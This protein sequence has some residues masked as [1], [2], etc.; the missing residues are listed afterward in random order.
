MK[1]KLRK[2]ILKSLLSA[3]GVLFLALEPKP[4]LGAERISFTL[5]LFGEFKISVADLEVFAKEG[6]ITSE[7][8]FYASRLDRETLIE[9]RQGLQTKFDVEPFTVYQFTT[10]PMGEQFLRGLGEVASTHSE[11]NG[12]YAIRSALILA[13]A[14]SEGL[15]PLNFLRHFPTDEIHLNTQLIFSLVKEINSFF[16]YKD[17]TVRAIAAQAKSELAAQ[18]EPDFEH[19]PDLRQPGE[20]LVAKQTKT[21][22]INAV[23]Q[24]DIGFTESY[25]LEA[26]IYLPEGI[27]KPAPLAIFSHGFTSNRHHFQDLARHLA[28]H[29]YIV[30]VPEHIGSDS[31]FKEAFLG[32]ELKVD[33]SPLEFYSRPLDISFLLDEIAEREE[34]NN[35]ID[36]NKVG[37]L[38]HSFGGNTALSMAGAPIDRERINQQCQENQPTLNISLLLQCRAGYLPPRNYNFKDPRIKAVVGINPVTSL[39]FGPEGMSQIDIPTMIVGGSN[40]VVAPFI[41]EQVHPFLWLTTEDKYLSVIEGGTH[42]ST[43]SKGSV[44]G[45]PDFLKG[46]RNDVG[47]S[48]VNALNLAFF[49]VYLRDRSEYRSFLS[50]AYASTISNEEL[51]L[52]AIASL[53]SEQLAQ[54]YGDTPPIP[55]IPDFI[56]TTTAKPKPQ[57]NILA[58]I[59]KTKTLKVGIRTD[60][61]PFG[62][63]D[64]SQNNLAGYC[65]DL[66]DSLAEHLEDE[67]NLTS[68]IEVIKIPS[69][70]QN[71]FELVSQNTVHLECGPNTI[72][73]DSA[74][75]SF[76]SPFFAS[77][78]RL[79]VENNPSEIDLES[80]LTELSLGVLSNTTTA[81]YL[82]TT[83]PEANLVYFQDR[84]G[85]SEGIK[86]V[87][88]GKIDAFVSEEV[89]L[90]S[91][92]QRQNLNPENYQLIPEQP[93]TCDFYGLILPQSDSQWQSTVNSFIRIQQTGK[94]EEKWL[95]EYLPQAISDADYCLNQ[96]DLY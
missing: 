49:E 70:L 38:G 14:D 83:Y 34:F 79:L 93:L 74:G 41:E 92:V 50:S 54:A 39:V 7:F 80:S 35:L 16:S 75:I 19:L 64:D 90:L 29:G 55:P 52:Y 33:V 57:Q 11:R 67:L 4:S 96:R 62:F 85:S 60:A 61:A 73:Q 66:T 71:R 76:S 72:R 5:P 25:N 51:P 26:D 82:E 94:S 17:A 9:L 13:A 68:P 42:S 86:A 1:R 84:G 81:R 78:S 46:V 12:L 10:K 36:W 45:F 32:G 63:I 20:Y 8:N 65:L 95:R 59:Q 47:K 43:S 44:A 56:V 21:F 69:N 87:N 24:T 91:E 23:R 37:I 77:G 15:T 58:E 22:N 31:K 89:L 3:C 6:V 30:L 88:S 53:T 2:L 40:D 18:P 28:S 48:Y 27:T